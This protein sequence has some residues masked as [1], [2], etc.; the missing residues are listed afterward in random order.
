MLFREYNGRFMTP[1]F[2]YLERFTVLYY[3]DLIC[4]YFQPIRKSVHQIN[5]RVKG[6]FSLWLAVFQLFLKPPQHFHLYL[7]L[8][9][10]L[11]HASQLFF[12]PDD[13]W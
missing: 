10:F 4:N 7:L 5:D 6:N 3:N 12:S 2:L 8:Q 11:Q 9:S 13:T 1:I